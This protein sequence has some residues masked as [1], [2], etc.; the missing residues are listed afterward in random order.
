MKKQ[1]EKKRRQTY[2]MLAD[3]QLKG[4]VPACRGCADFRLAVRAKRKSKAPK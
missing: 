1:R 4:Q 3:A 2:A